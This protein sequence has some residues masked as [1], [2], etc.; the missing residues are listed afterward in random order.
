[1]LDMLP[2]RVFDPF[3]GVGTTLIS[4]E[5]SGI[6]A[7]GIDAHPFVSKVTRAK[8]AYRSDPRKFY[9]IAQDILSFALELAPNPCRYPKLIQDCY[10]EDSLGE[11]DC[12]RTALSQIED[13]SDATTLAWLALATILR[14]TSHAGTAN[15]Q[16]VLPKHKKVN[17]KRPFAAY[18]ETVNMMRSDMITSS[19]AGPEAVFHVDDA[20]LCKSVPSQHFDLVI[21]S[22]P[23]PNNYDYADATRL[24]MTFFGEVERWRDLH[25]TVRCHLLRSCTQQV[26]EREVDLNLVLSRPELTPIADDLSEVCMRLGEERLNHGGKK[27]YHNMIACYFLDLAMVWI[28]LRRVCKSP[29]SACFVIGDS[30]PYGVYVPVPDWLGRLACAAGFKSFRFE[31]IRDRN[32]KWKNRKHRVPLCEGRLWVEG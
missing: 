7:W 8:L 16:Y 30:A 25:A 24:E 26:P 15:S 5:Q 18:D 29:S 22:P 14:P 12:L 4:A 19:V 20:R 11:L 3:V 13:G 17:V 31:K 1:M 2:E 27:N 21:T 9:S 23:Y 10:T 32:I 6:E 28:E